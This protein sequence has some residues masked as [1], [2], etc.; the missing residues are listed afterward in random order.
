MKSPNL[1]A[2]MLCTGL[3]VTYLIEKRLHFSAKMTESGNLKWM[4]TSITSR[5]DGAVRLIR[6]RA[7]VE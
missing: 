7:A 3:E 6:R 5:R 4:Q 1:T 2:L